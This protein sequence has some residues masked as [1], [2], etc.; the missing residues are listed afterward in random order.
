MYACVSISVR[1]NWK[2]L[3]IWRKKLELDTPEG[4][5]QDDDDALNFHQSLIYIISAKPGIV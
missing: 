3:V 5:C 1:W 2:C 4:V